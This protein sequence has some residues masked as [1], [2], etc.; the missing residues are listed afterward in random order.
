M[1]PRLKTVGKCGA[2]MV[3]LQYHNLLLHR[4]AASHQMEVIGEDKTQITARTNTYLPSDIQELSDYTASFYGVTA[5]L[6]KY[7]QLSH[8]PSPSQGFLDSLVD[9]DFS[10]CSALTRLPSAYAGKH[11]VRRLNISGTKIS[12]IPLTF[13]DSIVSLDVSNCRRITNV[14]DMEQLKILNITASAVVDLAASVVATIEQVIALNSKLTSIN[15]ATN[16]KVV[17]WSGPLQTTLQIDG[18]DELMTVVTTGALESVQCAS[19]AYV[20]SLNF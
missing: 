17:V 7:K 1:I 13:V 20:T 16:L 11:T 18:S 4:G 12:S 15:D 2:D 5:L 10:S 9:I 8:I 19:T 14:G 6:C 3:L